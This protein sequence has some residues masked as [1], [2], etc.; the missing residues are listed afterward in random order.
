MPGITSP[1]LVPSGCPSP[2]SV[3]IQGQI[4]YLVQEV[5]RRRWHWQRGGER[6]MAQP[7]G[8][9]EEARWWRRA[10]SV[11]QLARRILPV[12]A[13][14][15][16]VAR[17]GCSPFR[18][19]ALYLAVTARSGRLAVRR[20]SGRAAIATAAQSPAQA[21]ACWLLQASTFPEV[22]HWPASR[23][24]GSRIGCVGPPDALPAPRTVLR[25]RLADLAASRRSSS[26]S[27][28]SRSWLGVRSHWL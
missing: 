25:R 28:C 2:L 24:V 22:A 19:S 10:V 21:R 26:V 13:I 8:P 1:Y 3:C 18:L 23:A 12:P 11:G 6:R 15:S 5:R 14:D 9:A 16:A 17:G 20:Q 4:V 27:R 7:R